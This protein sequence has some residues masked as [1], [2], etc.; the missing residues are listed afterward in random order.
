M[1]F[2]HTIRPPGGTDQSCC[3]TRW[4][5][6]PTASSRWATTTSQCTGRLTGTRRGQS[7]TT[8][9]RAMFGHPAWAEWPTPRRLGMTTWIGC[10]TLTADTHPGTDCTCGTNP[11]RSCCPRNS[12]TSQ[13][14][15]R[16]SHCTKWTNIKITKKNQKKLYYETN[17]TKSPN[18]L[19][20]RH[21]YTRK[22]STKFSDMDEKRCFNI[23]YYYYCCKRRWIV[24]Y[25]TIKSKF[26]INQF[27]ER[28]SNR[29]RKVRR[30]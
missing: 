1:I 9:I 17:W 24:T 28:S 29:T 22:Q 19:L 11:A 18:T 10:E 14:R 20:H 25:Y 26:S 15:S 30:G 2:A 16:F 23:F 13:T 12:S 27:I 21:T 4:T 7:T 6:P 5:H 3:W 8:T